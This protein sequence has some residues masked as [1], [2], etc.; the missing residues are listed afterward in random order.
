MVPELPDRLLGVSIDDPSDREPT[1]ERPDEPEELERFLYVEL[2][3][4]RLAIPVDDVKTIADP[5]PRDDIT[6]IP[7]GPDPVEGLV[8][9][10]GEITAIIDA[11]VHFPVEAEPPE[12]SPLVVFDRPTDQQPAALRVDGA[13]GVHTIPEENVRG[14][15][16]LSD[17]TVA[18]GAIE[19]PLIEAIIEQEREESGSDTRPKRRTSSRSRRESTRSDPGAAAGTTISTPSFESGDERAP[20]STRSGPPRQ[21]ESTESTVVDEFVLEDDESDGPVDSVTDSSTVIVETTAVI[22]VQALLFASGKQ[23]Q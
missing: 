7:R 22:D 16:A 9:L 2:G 18:G 13:L 10:R 4:H 11:R 6:R 23:P 15:E 1:D 19:H 20:G 5:P 3:A 8:D 12:A 14:P 17:R 21:T